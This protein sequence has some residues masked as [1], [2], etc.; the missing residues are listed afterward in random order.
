VVRLDH[1]SAVFG[2]ASVARRADGAY[3]QTQRKAGR[4]R[5]TSARPVCIPLTRSSPR[6]FASYTAAYT[7]AGRMSLIS[8]VSWESVPV[9]GVPKSGRMYESRP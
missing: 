5:F 7:A 8:S 3:R 2:D 4:M 9:Q 1:Q 6:S